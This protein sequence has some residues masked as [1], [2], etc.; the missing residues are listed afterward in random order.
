MQQILVIEC[1]LFLVFN[2][3]SNYTFGSF[4]FALRKSQIPL[5]GLSLKKKNYL[6][7]DAGIHTHIARIVYT[8]CHPNY[9]RKAG[10]GRIFT[11]RLTKMGSSFQAFSIELLEWGR[12]SGL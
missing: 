5:L 6:S 3:C 9:G 8:S 12:T 1:L 10:W 7:T 11:P 2:T 4:R